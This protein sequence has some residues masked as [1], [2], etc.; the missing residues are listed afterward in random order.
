M[1]NH[2]ICLLALLAV[3][4]AGAAKPAASQPPVEPVEPVPTASLVAAD[5]RF[6][7]RLFG[8]LFREE[9]GKNIFI[10]PPSIALALAMAWNGAAG[11]TRSAMATALGLEGVSPAE[12]NP[13]NAARLA[14]LRDG[15]AEVTLEVAN[16][17]WSR[18][19]IPLAGDFVKTNRDYYGAE[20]A[21]LDFGTPEAVATI[22]RWVSDRTRGRIPG[23]IS[24]LAPE[25]VMVLLNAVYFKGAW[26]DA[27]KPEFTRERDFTLAGGTKKPCP[28]MA[29]SGDFQYRDGDGFQAA[30]LAYG[31][32]GY[33]MYLLLPA[34][35]VGALVDRL[36]AG[37]LGDWTGELAKRKGEVV[38]PRFRLEYAKRLND[39]LRRLGMD[40]AFDP[41][42]ADF[43]GML[44]AEIDMPFFISEVMHKSFVEVN[45]EG[46]EAAAATAVT[47]TMT[48]MPVEQERFSLV[49]DRPFICLIRDDRSGAILFLGVVNDPTE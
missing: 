21:E 45:E 7:A 26:T 40:I 8:E 30:R 31:E 6:G 24:R 43:R 32:G 4:C 5:N 1:T 47:M 3:G 28:M 29:R 39:V 22:N 2:A 18:R 19:G 41:A 25:D 27:F 12:V 33:A 23:I 48:A 44:G 20:A 38:L 13:A 35:G 16:S 37:E 10:S 34:G 17:I 14:A 46:T 11:E 15:D 9:P 42:R 49:C 36:A